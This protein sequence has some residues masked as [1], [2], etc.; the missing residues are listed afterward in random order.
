M[1]G[2]V[3]RGA[4][5]SGT[6]RR[7]ASAFAIPIMLA[8]ALCS[9]PPRIAAEDW[10]FSGSI[11]SSFTYRNLKNPPAG[12]TYSIGTEQYANL[13]LKAQ[14]GE[15]G[16]VY[17][18][19]NLTATA[20]YSGSIELERLYYKIAG[21]AFDFEAGLLRQAFGYGQ[22]WR[23]TDFLALPNPLSP[24]VR[25]RG[26]LAAAGSAYPRDG[27]KLK[28]LAVAGG[29]A[30]GAAIGAAAIGAA[31]AGG[32]PLSSDGDGSIFAL[33]GDWH[34][35]RSSVQGLYAFQAAA[36]GWDEATHRFGLSLKIEAGAAFV[37]DALYKLETKSA[38]TGLYHGESW[39]GLQGLG[40]SAGLD[41]SFLGGDLFALCQYLYSG[42]GA[43]ELDDGLGKHH[44]LYVALSYRIDDYT[45][46][47]L[48]S[49][50]GLE[51]A[52]AVPSV[53]FEHEPFQGLALA[54]SG[55]LPVDAPSL[56]MGGADG[57]LG[58][59]MS[60]LRGELGFTAK[61]KF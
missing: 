54:F 2:F 59:G 44:Y 51:D 5:R 53:A 1:S 18:A 20:S 26:V 60:G 19:A 16:T 43:A 50:V 49:V 25:P 40:A 31:A 48:S 52:S 30:P 35:N 36:T 8:L 6:A 41:Y 55:R 21:D 12:K 24:N 10:D 9:A 14:A 39:N 37:V 28:A 34:G 22:A 4:A 11:Q 32:I 61:L 33:S 15:F 56:G 45:R 46:A 58:P 42:D 38:K 47:T 13:R 7:R 17:A 27:L 57:E 3:F 29:T 23:P